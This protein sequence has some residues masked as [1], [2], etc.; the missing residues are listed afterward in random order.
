MLKIH[1]CLKTVT[2]YNDLRDVS[3]VGGHRY[4]VKPK[5]AYDKTSGVAKSIICCILKKTENALACS[6]KSAKVHDDRSISMAKKN[7]FTC[8]QVE[9]SLG[10][11]L[12]RFT[13][14]RYLHKW[15][16]KGFTTRQMTV[17][18]I[19]QELEHW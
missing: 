1:L 15:T 13:I 3:L 12:V 5:L 9:N 7:N 14:K 11:R 18:N 8:D 6:K 4:A 10:T 16:N 17:K 2:K 19:L